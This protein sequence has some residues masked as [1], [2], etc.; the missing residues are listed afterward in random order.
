MCTISRYDKIT[1]R[2]RGKLKVSLLAR[3]NIS[4]SFPAQ[5]GGSEVGAELTWK[6]FSRINCAGCVHLAVD[7]IA[8]ITGRASIPQLS[9]L[10]SVKALHTFTLHFHA[11]SSCTGD[12]SA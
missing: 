10:K 2:K 11:N 5:L 4:V 3:V 8:F 1:E 12:R 9:A 6:L 7:T